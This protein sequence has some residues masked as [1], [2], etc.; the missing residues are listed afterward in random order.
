MTRHPP[1]GT[2]VWTGIPL[3]PFNHPSISIQFSIHR[4][5]HQFFIDPSIHPSI[6]PSFHPSIHPSIHPVMILIVILVQILILVPILIVR[7]ILILST[8][9][10]LSSSPHHVL[11]HIHTT[12]LH[13]FTTRLQC[14]RLLRFLFP[15][16]T[17]MTAPA[18]TWA[19]PSKSSEL[20]SESESDL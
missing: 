13:V 16:S 14:L 7:L 6:H 2:K 12:R 11:L 9:Y 17:T 19:H 10:K 5:I 4:S 1:C 15:V 8:W 20:E 3:Y 18:T